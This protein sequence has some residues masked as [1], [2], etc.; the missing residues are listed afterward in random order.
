M[1]TTA[2]RTP[3]SGGAVIAPTFEVRCPADGRVVATL[4]EMGKANVALAAAELRAAQPEWEALGPDG[5]GK[6]LLN[7]LDWILDNEQRI[8]AL[9][10]AESGKSAGDTTIET[11]VAVEVINYYVK[12]ARK[13]LTDRSVRGHNPAAL[14]KSLR[15]FIRPQPLVGIIFPWNYPLGMPMM[16]VPPA[17]AA[18]AAVLTK[19]SEFTP[20][21]WTE[22]VRGFR[23]E[24]GAPP[25]SRA[26]R[27]AVRPAQRSSMRWT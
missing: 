11:M 1:A 10:Q 20:V 13:F 4:P 18:G 26:S 22:C 7:W 12:N 5:R 3:T 2:N 6:H 21:A 25:S 19:P 14:A 15:V 17:L 24:I 23:E 16:D 27:A 8:L 9:V